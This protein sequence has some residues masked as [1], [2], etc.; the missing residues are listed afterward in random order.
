MPASL[1]PSIMRTLIPLIAGWL[2]SLA[3]QA[4]V[5]IDSEKVTSAVTI[6]IV[7]AYYLAFRLLEFL[8]TKLRG[9]ALQKAAG[10]LLGWAR[11]PAYPDT[12][13]ALPPV[14]AYT[15]GPRAQ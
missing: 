8:G 12:G 9:T 7:L 5:E 14:T 15:S 13:G 1:F 3:V 10:F 4:G 6:A 2:L 11:P